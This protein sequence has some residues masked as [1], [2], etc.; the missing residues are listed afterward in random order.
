MHFSS[1]DIKYLKNN[2][3]ISNVGWSRRDMSRLTFLGLGVR[4]LPAEKIGF[5]NTPGSEIGYFF[6]TLGYLTGVKR[7]KNSEMVVF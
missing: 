6:L 2:L 5:P 7:R 3:T 1:P 4:F